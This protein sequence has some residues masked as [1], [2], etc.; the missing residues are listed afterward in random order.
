MEG[1]N[2]LSQMSVSLSL[3]G[4]E[5]KSLELLTN[6]LVGPLERNILVPS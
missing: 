2:P 6:R 3:F 4:L 5:I 1:F